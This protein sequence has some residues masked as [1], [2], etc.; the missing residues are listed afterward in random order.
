ME[1]YVERAKTLKMIN[2]KLISSEDIYFDIR[3][4]LNCRW[5]CED[6]VS[7]DNI[8]CHDR[9]TT[10]QERT[11]MIRSYQHVLLLHSHDA[12]QLS[13]A[14]LDIERAAFLDG[15]Y[16]ASSIRSCS[17]CEKCSVLDGGACPTPSKIR[18]CDQLFGI[19]VYK[20]A[21]ELG[22]P[23][24]VLKYKDEI[25]NRYGFVLID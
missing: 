4:I 16:F 9:G 25:Q 18:P 19:D 15:Y 2:A 10:Y 17:L 1:K 24:D 3:S 23:I 11:N 21:R 8:R 5:G 7:K 6:F 12:K 14:V 13:I 22:L 20:T